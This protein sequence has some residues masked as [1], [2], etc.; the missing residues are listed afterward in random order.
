MTGR[1]LFFLIAGL[2]TLKMVVEALV[3]MP[4]IFLGT[5]MG[6][7]FFQTAS[8]ERF[9]AALQA[10]LACGAVVLVGKGFAKMR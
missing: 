5:W 6:T 9:W 2:V 7:R 8:P 10:L 3:L 4:A 1:M